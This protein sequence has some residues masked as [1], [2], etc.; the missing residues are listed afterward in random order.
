MVERAVDED[1]LLVGQ[2]GLRRV[3][4]R[5]GST[6]REAARWRNWRCLGCPMAKAENHCQ[7]PPVNYSSGVPNHLHRPGTT[8]FSG[9]SQDLGPTR[10]STWSSGS[11]SV[12][13]PEGP[14]RG[15]RL[16]SGRDEFRDLRPQSTDHLLEGRQVGHEGAKPLSPGPCHGVQHALL[17]E[18]LGA[19]EGDP[20]HRALRR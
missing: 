7:T 3:E 15:N 16:S 20:P 9:T 10:Y 12:T 18:V 17:E 8:S 19:R 4:R 13:R 2:G 1:V 6:A 14:R 5:A 11:R